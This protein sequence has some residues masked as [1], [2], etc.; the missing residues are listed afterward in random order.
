MPDVN[1]LV[2]AHRSDERDH[3]AY[4]KWLEETV[5]NER[6]FALSVLI[7]VAFVRLVTNGRIFDPPTPLDV[8]IAAIDQLAEHPRCRV[9]FPGPGHW[10]DVARLS[11]ATAATG[12]H[13]ADAQH[14]ALAI[15]EGCTWVTPDDDFA[16]FAPHGL[17]WQH[18][19]PEP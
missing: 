16:K 17:A 2:Y 9:V 1:V 5:N 11:C 6:P 4:R 8:A 13:V 19:V 15:A 10:R 12:K 3:A 7:A 18:L 14:A